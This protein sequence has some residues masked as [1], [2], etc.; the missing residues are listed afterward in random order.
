MPVNRESQIANR[1]SYANHPP[2]PADT[3]ADAEELP[4]TAPIA[5]RNPINA[6]K[7][8]SEHLD[9]PSSLFAAVAA[10]SR[11]H[12]DYLGAWKALV[13]GMRVP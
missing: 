3:S 13:T 6:R 4:R 9:W 12:G 7:S 10:I 2:N 1:K 11:F 8:R 5:I